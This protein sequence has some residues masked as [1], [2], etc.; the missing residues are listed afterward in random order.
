MCYAYIT[1]QYV[2]LP[3]VQ[4]EWFWYG[5]F[6]IGVTTCD[7]ICFDNPLHSIAI[8]K[9]TWV[10]SGCS[11]YKNGEKTIKTYG[12]NLDQLSEGDRVGVKR[13]STGALHI[14]INGVDQGCAER[15]LPS[16]VW[17]VLDIGGRCE[18]VSLVD[19]IN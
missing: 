1:E 18:Q 17:A 19:D 7:Q 5:F 2:C 13:T 11:I 14:Y 15:E 10:M 12:Q 8:Q 3:V 4:A 9:D 6:A 16:R